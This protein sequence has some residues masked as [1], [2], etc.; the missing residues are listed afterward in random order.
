M[1]GKWYTIASGSLMSYAGQRKHRSYQTYGVVRR[2]WDVLRENENLMIYVSSV[3]LEALYFARIRIPCDI[4]AIWYALYSAS[5][6]AGIYLVPVEIPKRGY[7][8][9]YARAGGVSG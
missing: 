8:S 5:D 4:R 3:A 2:F 1:E 6:T 7:G 9:H